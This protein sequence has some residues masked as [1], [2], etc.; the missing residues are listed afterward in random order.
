MHRL[1]HRLFLLLIVTLALLV[2][3]ACGPSA[4]ERQQAEQDRRHAMALA[5]VQES[6]DSNLQRIGQHCRERTAGL[7]TLLT[8]YPDFMVEINGKT[9]PQLEFAVDLAQASARHDSI[10]SCARLVD[11]VARMLRRERSHRPR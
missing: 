9:E 2:P 10:A 4:E 8:Q 11:S 7:R 5:L 3:A 6:M 1:N